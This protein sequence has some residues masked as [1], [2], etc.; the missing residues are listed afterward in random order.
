[1]ATPETIWKD[2]YDESPVLRV[3]GSVLQL[4]FK[5][6]IFHSMVHNW[7]V[8]SV[9]ARSKGGVNIEVSELRSLG[10]GWWLWGAIL[11]V[12]LALI[13][14]PRRGWIALPLSFLVVEGLG[15]LVGQAIA[16]E[17]LDNDRRRFV[18]FMANVLN[19]HEAEAA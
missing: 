16:D 17:S 8:L 2:D 19:A 18:N 13:V 4:R 5:R 15:F 9:A 11:G 3:R 7:F 14:G 12:V 6:A 10:R 1:M